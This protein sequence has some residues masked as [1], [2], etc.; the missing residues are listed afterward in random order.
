[1]PRYGWLE[2]CKGQ[3]QSF[4][5][6]FSWLSTTKLLGAFKCYKCQRG[7]FS[8]EG[9]IVMQ[10][11]IILLRVSIFFL[12]TLYRII[13]VEILFIRILYSNLFNNDAER[14][15]LEESFFK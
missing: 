12:M 13:Q 7:I 14:V 10:L 4:I 2:F 6:C 8:S 5:R 1:M 3:Q 11:R 15:E 9:T